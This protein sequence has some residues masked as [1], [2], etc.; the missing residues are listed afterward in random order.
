L[1]LYN[2]FLME[3]FRFYTP[4]EVAEILKVDY[5]TILRWIKRGE[6]EAVRF[7][8]RWRIPLEAL[9][10]FINQ[11]KVGKEESR[12]EENSIME[13]NLKALL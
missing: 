9:E 4:K 7:G 13:L 8:T 10:K 12:E 6:L 1:I 5:Y 2:P 11:H 3:R